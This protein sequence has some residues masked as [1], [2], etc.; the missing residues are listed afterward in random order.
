MDARRLEQ[1][2]QRDQQEADE[3]PDGEVTKIR[4]HELT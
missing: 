2:E 3:H 4:V 1:V